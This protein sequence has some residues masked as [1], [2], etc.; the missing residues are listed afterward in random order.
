MHDPLLALFLLLVGLGCIVGWGVCRVE[1]EKR[2]L[3]L[4]READA[5]KHRVAR[6]GFLP[7]GFPRALAEGYLQLR[8]LDVT[9]NGFLAAGILGLALSH[10][11][12]R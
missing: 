6:G 5:I 3:R 10:L 7:M 1:T 4:R 11:L 12:I 9:A 2:A 8:F